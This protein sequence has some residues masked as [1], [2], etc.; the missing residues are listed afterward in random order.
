LITPTQSDL[1]RHT[2]LQLAAF[3]ENMDRPQQN[4]FRFLVN[5]FTG[6][7]DSILPYP[8][9]D[10]VEF[11]KSQFERTPSLLRHAKQNHIVPAV[12]YAL[13]NA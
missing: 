13:Q 10:P 3:I 12:A 7:A 4:D 8:G 11:T 5:Q 2:A 1:Y 9:L 6:I